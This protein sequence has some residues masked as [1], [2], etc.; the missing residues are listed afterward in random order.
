MYLEKYSNSWE[1]MSQKSDTTGQQDICN[2]TAYEG[3]QW[4]QNDCLK[5]EAYRCKMQPSSHSKPQ[6]TYSEDSSEDTIE[7]EVEDVHARDQFGFRR[8]KGTTDET[9]MLRIVS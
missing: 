7:T 4:S 6:G 8:G 3:L 2:R 5:E 9:G 1:K